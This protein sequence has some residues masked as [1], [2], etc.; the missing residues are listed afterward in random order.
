MWLGCALGSKDL[1]SSARPREGSGEPDWHPRRTRGA[2]GWG[3]SDEMPG[4]PIDFELEFS[5]FLSD[6]EKLSEDSS[7]AQR[8]Q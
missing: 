1:V 2:G 4:A 7:W 8:T 6:L 5:E 3:G